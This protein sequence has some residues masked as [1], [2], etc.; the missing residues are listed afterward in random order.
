[1]WKYLLILTALLPSCAAYQ[2][3]PVAICAGTKTDRK[4][5]AAALVTDGGPKSRVTGAAVLVKM[6]AGCG[7]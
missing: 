5:H 4:A 2:A 6:E 3:D 7:E 1:M